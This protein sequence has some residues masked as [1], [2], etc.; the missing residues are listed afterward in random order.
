[1]LAA[2]PTAAGAQ[3][4]TPEVPARAATDETPPPIPS[5]PI[6]DDDDS[7]K[8]DANLAERVLVSPRE[9]RCDDNGQVG[10]ITVCGKKKDNSKDRLPIP[11]LLNSATAT[12][13]GL[14]RAP[15]MMGNRITGH[16][17]KFGCIVCP[18]AMLPDIDFSLLP[19]DPA[20]SDADRIGR[21]E[22]RGN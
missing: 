17:I 5:L 14:P 6:L 21:G 4:A 1:L 13:D 22:I 12:G 7:T 3:A 2:A 15:D 16:S 9:P 19:P 18:K 10:G 8:D 20:G 11:G